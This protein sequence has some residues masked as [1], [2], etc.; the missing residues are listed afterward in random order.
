MIEGQKLSSHCYMPNLI[1]IMIHPDEFEDCGR[2]GILIFDH[3]SPDLIL[4]A[5]T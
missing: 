5:V 2:L 3:N 1:A 4:R